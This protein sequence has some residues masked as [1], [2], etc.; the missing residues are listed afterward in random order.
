[1]KDKN[2][3]VIAITGPSGSG[4]TYFAKKIKELFPTD[5]LVMGFD[6]Y[7]KDFSKITHDFSLL[8]YDEPAS[9]DGEQLAKDIEQLKRNHTIYMPLYDFVTHS[10]KNETQ[11]VTPKKIIL[12]EGL[13]PLNYS[14]LARQIDYVVYI[15]ALKETRFSRRLS[16]DQLE[17]GRSPESI[18]NQWDKF[19]R[20]MELIHVLPNKIKANLII[21]NNENNHQYHGLDQIVS[22]IKEHL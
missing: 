20:P 6:N 21:D 1:M 13:F 11:L 16:R 19:V 18:K 5:L 17:R 15:D 12:I 3:F 8:N 7:C 9:Y 4:K 14:A 2:N 10:R 22:I